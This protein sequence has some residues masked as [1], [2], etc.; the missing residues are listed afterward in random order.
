MLIAV[1]AAIVASGVTYYLQQRRIEQLA[2]QVAAKQTELTALAAQVDAIN[3]SLQS[4]TATGAVDGDDSAQVVS[5]D[6]ES[7]DAQ[8]APKPRTHHEQAVRAREEGHRQ[9][10]QDEPRARLR[11]VPLGGCGRRRSCGGR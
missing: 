10:R 11:A 4:Q 5:T 9:E 6:D 3:A 8:A 7:T 1:L 2:A